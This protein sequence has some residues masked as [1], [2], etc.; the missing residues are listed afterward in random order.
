MNQES[1]FL[2]FFRIFLRLVLLG[3]IVMLYWSSILVEHDLKFVQSDLSQIQKD[4]E[5]MKDQIEKLKDR[6]TAEIKET[7]SY[8]KKV[9]PNFFYE[10][11]LKPDPFYKMTLPK[12]LGTGF[13]PSGVRREATIGKP[14]DLHPL[15]NWAQVASWNSLCTVSLTTQQFGIY[16]TFAPDMA[17]TMELRPTKEGAMEYWLNLRKD[18][19]WQPL[20]RRDFEGNIELASVFF[21]KHQV[22]A[23]DIKFFFDA[24]MNPHIGEEQAVVLRNYLNDIEEV[25]VVDDFTLVV[26][27]KG[28]EVQTEDGKKQ[29]RTKYLSKIHTGSLRP[30][31]RFVYQYF[32]DGTKIIADDA[33][34]NTYRHNPIWAQNFSQHWAKQIIVSCGPWLFDGM[35]DREIRFRRVS[36]FYEPYAVLVDKYEVKFRDTPESIW[37]EFKT[38]SL[39]L[40][41]VPPNLL[42]EFEQFL[43]SEPY[44]Q[45]LKQGLEIQQL[46]YPARSYT[47]VGWNQA[48]QLF[49]S[50]KIRQALTLAID[51]ER[52]IRQN[53]NG[54]GIQITG[55]F[56]PYSPSYD[57]SLKPY[58]FDP[59]QALQL[60]HEEGWYDSDG[61]GI[62]DKEIDGIR[63]PFVFKLTYYVKNPTTKSICDYI[64]TALKEIGI[65]CHLN[66]VDTADLSISFEDKSFD[67]IYLGWALGAPPEDPKQLWYSTGAKEKGSSNAISFA[68][69]EV[70]RIIDQLEYEYNQKKRI[71]LYHR[72]D[73][74]L[75]EEAPYT[76]LYAPIIT[77]A[78]RNYLQNVFIP[79]KRQDLIP[80]ANVG[81]PQSSIFWIKH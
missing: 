42:P 67:A 10:N 43:Q 41:E 44:Q 16:E 64:A 26:R 20:N 58:P 79:A 73:A 37:E 36:D 39:D 21:Q 32:A 65:V 8:E 60:L 77:L 9:I 57:S 47:Y 29:L 27:W 6:P 35:T 34:P 59:D 45:Q 33:D 49:K 1:F 72:F 53:L 14:F 74:I 52:I 46:E 31:A 76:F 25:Q 50:R 3:L 56:F 15:S 12:L 55:T 18:L 24:V 48:N 69:V 22:T 70:D 38:G 81:E 7:I 5:V 62:L 28:I 54:K 63:V 71:E 66:G 78:Y 75:Y 30:L 61:D 40:F 19:F 4:I 13:K 23:H 17:Y 2:S 80:G 11:L 51:R 68:N